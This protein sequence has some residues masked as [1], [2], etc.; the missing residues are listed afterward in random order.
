MM[1]M[2]GGVTDMMGGLSVGIVGV[3]DPMSMGMSMGGGSEPMMGGQIAM[4][5]GMDMGMGMQ[6]GMDMGMGPGEMMGGS[7]EPM[8]GPAVGLESSGGS[9]E[10]EIYVSPGM[11]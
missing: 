4:P 1:I 8:Q 2:M 6:M 11:D 3:G 7:M 9:S 10:G 5:M